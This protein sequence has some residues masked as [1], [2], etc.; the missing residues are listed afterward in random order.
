M[1]ITYK[2]LSL[3]AAPAAFFLL[4]TAGSGQQNVPFKG[5]IPVAPTGLAGRKLPLKPMVYDTGEGQK[6][7]VS[8]V[9]RALETPFGIA[10]LPGGDMLVTERAARLRIIR[11]GVLDPKP[12]AGG[13]V[14]YGTG[15]SGL[16]GAVHGYMDVVLHPGFAQN[17]WIYI[18]YTKTLSGD[19]RVAAVARATWDGTKLTDLKDIIV[20][21]GG[22]PTRMVF[23]RD[24]LLYLGVSGD[25]PQSLKTHGGKILRI[26]DDGSIP[27]DNPF[28]K[29]AGAKPEIFTLGH[30]NTLGLALH[31]GTGEIWQNENG[32]NGGDEINVLKAGANYGWPVVSLGRTY[33]GPWQSQAPTHVGFES[34]VVYWTPAIAV[35]GMTFYT[36]DK[37]PKWK[38]DVFVGSLRTGEIPGTGHVDRILFNTKMEELRRESLLTD[39]HQRIRDIRQGPD[40]LLYVL[41]DEKEGAVLKIEPV[42]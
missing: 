32:P 42:Q 2:H 19:K 7:R 15:E 38:G 26:K 1:R 30:R 17:K 12:V 31:P 34:P 3:L 28:L 22:G 24:N 39:L 14:G 23:G 25:D 16:P 5:G 40:G 4:A 10:F 21:E 35:S 41:T 37:F 8:V 27:A 36:G 18:S 33:P 9:T 13:P 20:T 11:K 29:V 6:I